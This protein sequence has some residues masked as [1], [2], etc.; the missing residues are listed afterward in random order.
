MT[1]D[2]ATVLP[3][4]VRCTLELRDRWLRLLTVESLHAWLDAFD[5]LTDTEASIYCRC[6]P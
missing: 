3:V 6:V 2:V 1:L 4:C 5:N